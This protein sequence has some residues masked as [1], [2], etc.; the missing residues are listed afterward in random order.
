MAILPQPRKNKHAKL[1]HLSRHRP[2][3]HSTLFAVPGQPNTFQAVGPKARRMEKHRLNQPM[4][5]SFLT[6]PADV[7]WLREHAAAAEQAREAREA[8]AADRSTGN[9]QPA[10]EPMSVDAQHHTLPAPQ[11][12]APRAR[13]ARSRRPRPEK[14]RVYANWTVLLPELHEPYLKRDASVR[15]PSASL[16]QE[17]D[18]SMRIATVT[19]VFWN[20]M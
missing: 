8:Q 13:A 12:P 18:C 5:N 17:P 6:V 16:C 9:P 19:C 15:A 14:T 7:A 3:P 20:R 11:Y 4:Q 10:E 1:K 2:G